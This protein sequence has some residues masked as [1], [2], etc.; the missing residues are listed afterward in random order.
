MGESC[1]APFVVHDN[2]DG[3]DHDHDDDAD[4][5]ADDDVDDGDDVGPGRSLEGRVPSERRRGGPRGNVREPLGGTEKYRR[6]RP[7]ASIFEP[8]SSIV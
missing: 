4:D 7:E 1:V 6:G 8:R 3:D 5:D 2:D